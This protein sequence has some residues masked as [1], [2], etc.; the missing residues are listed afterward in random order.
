MPP[1]VGAHCLRRAGYRSATKLTVF[2]ALAHASR[3]EPAQWRALVTAHQRRNLAEYKGHVDEDDLLF[4][5]LLHTARA[6]LEEVEP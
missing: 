6:L 4:D 2:Q 1:R 3:L 5:G